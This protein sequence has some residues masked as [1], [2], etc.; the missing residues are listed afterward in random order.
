MK[1]DDLASP[2]YRAQLQQMTT[3]WA[4]TAGPYAEEVLELAA[5]LKAGSIL[6]YGCGPGSL[7]AALASSSIPVVGYDPGFPGKERLPNPADLV[8]C[9]D[10][11]EHIEPDR[12]HWVLKHIYNLALKGAL[13]V[14]A[15]RPAEKR[16]PDGRNA[17][18]IIDNARWW[19]EQLK[20]YSWSVEIKAAEGKEWAKF[21]ALKVP[22]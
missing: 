19:Y 8:V 12:L 5:L 16:L 10:V 21:W 7:Q 2:D 17:H 20:A 18:L 9:L 11:L 22:I 6:D 14:V 3:R 1:L 15:T 13:F 4:G